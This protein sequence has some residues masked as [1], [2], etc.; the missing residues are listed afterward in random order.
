M[1]HELTLI[2]G[3]LSALFI[4]NVIA[5]AYA[6]GRMHAWLKQHG[7]PFGADPNIQRRLNQV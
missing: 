5:C 1:L 7:E 2:I 3:A 4:V 6:L